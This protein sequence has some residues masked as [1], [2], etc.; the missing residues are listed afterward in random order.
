MDF[1]DKIKSLPENIYDFFISNESLYEIKKSCWLYVD[2]E[3]IIEHLAKP[4]GLIFAGEEGLENLPNIIQQKNINSDIAYG[5]SYEINSRIFSRFPEYFTNSKRLLEN[6]EKLKSEPLISE[7]QAWEK[8]L[9]TEP[10]ILEEK[11]KNEEERRREMK[12][13]EIRQTPKNILNLNISDAMKKFPEIGEQLITSEH[14]RLKSFPEPVRPSI[15]NWISDY[16]FNVGIS[17]HDQMVRMDYLFRNINTQKLSS[18]EREKLTEIFKSFDENTILS[19]DA[20]KKQVIFLRP[21]EKPSVKPASFSSSINLRPSEKKPEINVEE[22]LS[23]WRRDLNPKNENPAPENQNNINFSSPHKFP[24]EKMN[25]QKNFTP[26]E[27]KKVFSNSTVDLS[28][29]QLKNPVKN[30]FS[31]K[32]VVNLKE[33]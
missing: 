1:S 3:E 15:K 17:N 7:N 23:N 6:W 24:I 27:P 19:I 20:D 12:K 33:D 26:A 14:I 8:I 18:S 9:E 4:I 30:N 21:Q 28:N 22:R 11:K 32:N 13:E 5:I 31:Q 16:M 10:W 25:S 29:I 2:S